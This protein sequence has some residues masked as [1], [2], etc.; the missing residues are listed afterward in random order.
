MTMIAAS[1]RTLILVENS[2]RKTPIIILNIPQISRNIELAMYINISDRKH[3]TPPGYFE[4][5]LPGILPIPACIQIF[6]QHPGCSES[7]DFI[8]IT[9][10]LSAG[11]VEFFFSQLR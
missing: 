11:F 9:F 10:N 4:N 8:F 6:L 1:I 7:I 2:N 5:I 3:V